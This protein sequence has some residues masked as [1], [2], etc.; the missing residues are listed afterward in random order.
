M[1]TRYFTVVFVIIAL[2]TKG[3]GKYKTTF[4]FFKQK[5]TFLFFRME[6]DYGINS[7]GL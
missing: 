2:Q 7:I 6:T 5:P 4:K 1:S 3:K